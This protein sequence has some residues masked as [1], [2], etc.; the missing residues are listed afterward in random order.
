MTAVEAIKFEADSHADNTHKVP[1]KQ[2]RR[3]SEDARRVFNSVYSAMVENKQF[4]AHPDAPVVADQHWDTTA[5][6]AAW[7]AAESVR[8]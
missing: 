4:F 8:A 2:W 7:H 5:W 3:W 1:K 6:N